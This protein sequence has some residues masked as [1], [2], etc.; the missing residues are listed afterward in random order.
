MNAYVW[1]RA[2]V[3]LYGFY[4]FALVKILKITYTLPKMQEL[5]TYLRLQSDYFS[6]KTP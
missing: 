1:Y 2:F 5:R 4:H 6:T 3:S